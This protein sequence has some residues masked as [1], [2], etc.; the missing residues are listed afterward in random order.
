M[1][2]ARMRSLA[3]KLLIS[4]GATV[5]L[6]GLALMIWAGFAMSKYGG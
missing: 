5:L 4:A 3:L 2:E 6:G 1:A